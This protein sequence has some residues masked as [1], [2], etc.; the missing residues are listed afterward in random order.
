MS[1]DEPPLGPR[2]A[3]NPHPR[4]R[5]GGLILFI[6]PIVLVIASAA[7]TLLGADSMRALIAGITITAVAV[8]GVE[9]AKDRPRRAGYLLGLSVVLLALIVILEVD[10]R[11]STR[12]QAAG[13]SPSVSI[14]V[15]RNG[16]PV[17]WVSRD[18]EGMARNLPAGSVIW[19]VVRLSNGALY[20][21]TVPCKLNPSTSRWVCDDRSGVYFGIAAPSAGTYDL[22]ALIADG[23]RQTQLIYYVASIRQE[24][25]PWE[26]VLAPKE[27]GT[28]ITVH[29]NQ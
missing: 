27:I 17:P 18:I 8:F 7:T 6:A 23:K 26:T 2:P 16:A 1:T 21:A 3:G 9:A 29:R 28:T 19:L 5:F 20:P 12:A 11:S 10:D 14:D 13:V 4:A 24:T 22:V 15:P 25:V